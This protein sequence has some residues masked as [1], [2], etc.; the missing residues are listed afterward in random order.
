MFGVPPAFKAKDAVEEKDDDMAVF[1]VPA[2][3]AKEAVFGTK[4]ILDAVAEV[5][6]LV[7]ISALNACEALTTVKLILPAT[8]ANDAEVLVFEFNVV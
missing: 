8:E 7:A 5:T 2:F 3:A 6:A 1:A 4:L